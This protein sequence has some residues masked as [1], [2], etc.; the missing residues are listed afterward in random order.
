MLIECIRDG[1]GAKWDDAV[2]TFRPT[3]WGLVAEYLLAIG[4]CS[5]RLADIARRPVLDRNAAAFW[6]SIAGALALFMI[7]RLFYFDM[8]IQVLLRCAAED[9]GWYRE[10]RPLQALFILGLIA[11]GAAAASV[12]ILKVRQWDRRVALIGASALTVFLLVRATSLHQIDWRLSHKVF[13]LHWHGLGEALA[14]G[15]VMLGAAIG[16]PGLD[17]WTGAV[18]HPRRSPEDPAHDRH[19]P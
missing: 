13:G 3:G 14:I 9:H 11:A 5:W 15:V 4:L 12:F 2:L 1:L 17:K 10:R 6:S 8:F 16:L 19:N 7:L 18:Q